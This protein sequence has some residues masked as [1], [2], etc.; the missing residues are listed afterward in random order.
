MKATK[1]QLEK[2]RELYME[3]M[4]VSHIASEVGLT[5]GLVS[6]HANEKWKFERDMQKAELFQQLADAKRADFASILLNSTKIIKRAI[7]D[8]ANRDMPPTAREARSMAEVI[9][10]FD[11]I[12]RLDAGAPTDISE[13]RA[14]DANEIQR[15]VRMDPFY[16]EDA[17]E[18]DFKEVPK[19]T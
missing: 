9:E 19:I 12:L 6:Y 8:L 11:K 15:K 4:P 17:I 2:A 14:V 16:K 10:K 1:E 13:E 5:R 3:Y 7:E 18:A